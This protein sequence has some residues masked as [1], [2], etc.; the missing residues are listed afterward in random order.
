L[1][2]HKDAEMEKHFNPKWDNIKSV[3]WFI[4]VIEILILFL[5]IICGRACGYSNSLIGFGIMGLLIG[6]CLLSIVFAAVGIDLII[7]KG[8]KLLKHK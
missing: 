3:L 8:S 2:L 6:I 5:G 4:F 1:S 7:R